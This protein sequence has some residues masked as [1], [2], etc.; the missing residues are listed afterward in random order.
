MTNFINLYVDES[1]LPNV[2]N[3]Y[4]R[5]FL[6]TAL[7]MNPEQDEL[8]GLLMSKWRNSYLANPFKCLHSVDFFEDRIPNYKKRELRMTRRFNKATR[9]LLEMIKYIDF[10]AEVYYVDLKSLRTKYRIGIPPIDPGRGATV[11]AKTTYT[12]AKQ[13]YRQLIITQMGKKTEYYPLK[14]CLFRSFQK[15]SQTLQTS[16]DNK[17]SINLESIATSDGRYVDIYHN[18]ATSDLHYRHGNEIIGM[19]LHTKASTNGGGIEIADFISY[20]SLQTLR[21]E[22]KL[23]GELSN[24]NP[25]KLRLF[26]EIRDYMR[27]KFSVH[28]I[29]ITGD[30]V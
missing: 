29:D 18:Y 14:L 15:H 1:G 23:R 3:P 25:S 12:Q 7:T 22:H 10:H 26:K 24:I 13:D 9:D 20:I 21:K 28:L 2:G 4:Y 30:A 8:A 19:N 17:G 5:F 11:S 6:M 16:P 27:T